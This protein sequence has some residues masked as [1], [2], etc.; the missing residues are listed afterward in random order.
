MTAKDL[1]LQTTASGD[2]SR[3]AYPQGATPGPWHYEWDADGDHAIFAGSGVP[4]IAVTNGYLGDLDREQDE[5]NARLIAAAP[6]LLEIVRKV[7]EWKDCDEDNANCSDN[8]GPYCAE[9]G[10]NFLHTKLIAAAR[11]V[12]AAAEG[13]DRP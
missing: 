10:D 7:A 4:L 1:T 12:L 5:A 13:S 2:T 9:H 8:S 6:E 3:V 11:K